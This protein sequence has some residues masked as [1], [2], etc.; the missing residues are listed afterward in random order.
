LPPEI[1]S[2]ISSKEKQA[3]E[4]AA[5]NGFD[6][7]ADFKS[8]FAAAKA[9]H[10]REAEQI[11]S[12]LFKDT[13]SPAFKTPM[14]QVV[15][16]TQMAYAQFAMADPGLVM[17]LGKDLMDSLPAN[18][19]YFG[20]TDP[21]RGLPTALC[22]APG[23]PVFV[24]TQNHLCDSRY[25][26]YVRDMY[27]SS[28]HLPT[29]DEVKVPA[30][31][32]M[33]VMRTNAL[34]AR[35]IFDKN[36]DREF[37]YEQSFPLDWMQ[38]YLT[39]HGVLLKLNRLPQDSISTAE[40]TRDME[41]WS[42]KIEKLRGNPLFATDNTRKVYAHLR[43]VIAGV[44]VWRIQTAKNPIDQQRMTQAAEQAYNQTLELFA[45]S[46]EVVFGYINLEMMLG[47]PGAAL[48]FARRALAS[49]DDENLKRSLPN[50]IQT[51]EMAAAAKTA[52]KN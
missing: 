35:E 16:D 30:S 2:F 4:I 15:A 11:R 45:G 14:A 21:G 49:S 28:I 23:D 22:R 27:G 9:G 38:P 39:P 31:G 48:N 52:P 17:G 20:G 1:F 51:L 3:G 37:Y 43:S 10:A 18:C 42:G 46:P 26:Q 32:Y 25:I 50:V 44:Y 13:N 5:K 7:G 34:I 29:A 12:G 19:I 24:L 47:K 41:F 33:D 8:Y 36:P 40:V 6:L